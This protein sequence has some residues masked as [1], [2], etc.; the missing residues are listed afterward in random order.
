MWVSEALPV[1]PFLVAVTGYL[2]L[3]WHGIKQPTNMMQGRTLGVRRLPDSWTSV[4]LGSESDKYQSA[5]CIRT[6]CIARLN[7]LPPLELV[8]VPTEPA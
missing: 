8:R 1:P 3:Y 2:T 6:K 7:L 4:R 5:P